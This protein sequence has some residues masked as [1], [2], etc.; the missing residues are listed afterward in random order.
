[1]IYLTET[2]DSLNEIIDNL[3]N[4]RVA[5]MLYKAILNITK[6]TQTGSIYW[7]N[8]GF[9]NNIDKWDMILKE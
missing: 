6:N 1:M 5:Y 9:A 8:L 4:L 2:L 3:K 7:R